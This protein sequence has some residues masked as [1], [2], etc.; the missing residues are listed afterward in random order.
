MRHPL[1][2]LASW[3]PHALF[4]GMPVSRWRE[5]T[6]AGGCGWGAGVGWKRVRMST[7]LQVPYQLLVPW[8]HGLADQVPRIPLAGRTTTFSGKPFLQS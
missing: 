6:T 3:V 4:C 5:R 8:P 7:A 2:D 1:A